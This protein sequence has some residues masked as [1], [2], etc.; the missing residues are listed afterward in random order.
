VEGADTDTAEVVARDRPPRG[1][2]PPD[3]LTEDPILEVQELPDELTVTVV[4]RAVRGLGGPQLADTSPDVQLAVTLP[5]G[6]SARLDLVSAVVVVIGVRGNLDVHTLSGDVQVGGAGGEVH[7]TTVSG[8][9]ELDGDILSLHVTTT[10]GDVGVV[11]EL[12]RTLEARSVSGDVSIRAALDPGERFTF[13]SVSGDLEL[14]TPSGLTIEHR[15]LSG[16]V[17]SA[18]PSRRE[19]EDGRAVTVV[20]DGRSRLQA[21]TVSGDVVVSP[22]AERSTAP[23]RPAAPAQAAAPDVD[24]VDLD[25]LRALERGE[26]DIGEAARRLEDRHGRG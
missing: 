12:L 3:S 11:A 14:A 6:T 5:R 23:A 22:P 20:G 2:D 15:G 19:R 4:G 7:V 17:R 26:I 1:G 18:L 10:S 13:E 24:S 9:V 16:S 21:R 8:A 25:I